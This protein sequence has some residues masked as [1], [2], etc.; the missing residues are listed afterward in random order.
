M[1]LREA[2]SPDVPG[3]KGAPP[4]PRGNSMVKVVVA[5]LVG[6]TVEW[7]DFFLYGAAAALI[8]NKLFFPSFD[9]LVGTL[10]AF[11]TYA[12]GFV[13]RPLGGVVFGHFGDKLGRKRMLV[14]SLTIMGAATFCIGLLPSYDAV[15]IWAPL[16]LIALRLIQ[17]FALGGEWG[18]AVLMAAEHG[19]ANKRGLYASWPQ[20]GAPAGQL[21]AVTVLA[22]VT[23]T[24]NTAQFESWGWRIP[25][26][27]SAV[28][29]LVGTYIRTSIEESP[30][31]RAAQQSL[32]AAADAAGE[33]PVKL[34][35]L[36][37]LRDYRREVALAIGMRVA[38]NVSYYIFTAFILAYATQEL[39]LSRGMVLN[40]VLIASAIHFFAIP[41][42]GALSDR[43]GRRPLYLIGGVGVGVWG[44][45]F[46]PLL[47]T[48]S[49]PLIVLAAT[50]ALIFHGAMY[51]PQA[52]FFSELF[53]TQVR[54]S[55]LSVAGQL[56][57]I[58]A[59]SVAPLIATA[60]LIRYG[61]SVPIS[62]YLAG[63]AVLTVGCVLL[64]KE[65][66]GRDLTTVAADDRSE[67]AHA[68]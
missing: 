39:D 5:S 14:I 38:E 61:S 47:D 48:K 60:L 12:V 44:F 15:G 24:T 45:V 33:A 35:V 16:G 27:L 31:F 3:D 29:V 67:L 19:P 37:V 64:S 34:P 13:A 46:F 2:Y 18:G 51:G 56:S 21:L 30:V 23:A 22:V 62:I 50:M 54:Y 26:L 11:A 25:F 7:Y 66:A 4:L 1:S 40:A 53:A 9:P 68:R 58:V 6:T 8:F 42:F 32:E 43:V 28:L 41:L 65:T 57:S 63:A 20:A 17:G 52:A 55:G 36:Q 10:L 49:F 59:G